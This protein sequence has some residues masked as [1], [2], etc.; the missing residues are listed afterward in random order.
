MSADTSN[1]TRASELTAA[2]LRSVA[3][4]ISAQQLSRLTL[5]EIEAVV[6]MV[7]KI[8]PAGNVPGMILSGLAR[9]PGRRIPVQKLQQDVTALFSGVEQIL[10][11]AVYGAFFAGP[12]AVL[13]RYQNLL[14]LA[15]KD[16][17]SAF[18]EGMWQFYVDY[19]L[20]ED[21]ARHANET[22]G[23]DTLLQQHHIHLNKTDRLTAWFMSAVTCLHQYPSCSRM[24]GVNGF[25]SHYWSGLSWEPGLKPSVPSE[26]CGS[27]K[28]NVRIG[29]KQMVRSMTTLH[30]AVNSSKNL[31][32]EN[33][34][35]CLKRLKPAGIIPFAVPWG[36]GCMPINTKCP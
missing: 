26:F 10:D 11:Q 34:K 2:S 18:P 35:L 25:R 21:T 19:A 33:F 30:I 5:P 6:Q 20:R 14:R 4:T 1:I 22:H 27:G 32:A 28:Q 16:P 24:N 3:K 12:A 17:E 9:L 29:E 8:M 7:S 31:C 15:G 23:F 13:W 36:K